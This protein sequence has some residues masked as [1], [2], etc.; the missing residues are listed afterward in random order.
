MMDLKNYILEAISN[1]YLFEMADSRQDYLADIR[2]LRFQILEN[3]CLIKYCNMFDKEN[4]NRLHWSKE[5]IAH[6]DHLWRI[7][8]K[9]GLNKLNITEYGFY[10]KAEFD[11][12]DI[13][14]D[15]LKGKWDDEN[16]PDDKMFVVANEFIQ[17][18][19]R[20]CKMI[21]DK[22]GESIRNYVYNE[23]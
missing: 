15:A 23:L 19:P 2:G 6:L 9:K 1:T 16:L 5:L 14:I 21:S 12:I 3:W 8:L 7:S 20:I 17:A 10:E 13:V 18:L 4:Y 11:D 22:R